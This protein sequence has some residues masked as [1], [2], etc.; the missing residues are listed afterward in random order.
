MTI[1]KIQLPDGRI[2]RFEVPQ[3]STEQ[4]VMSYVESNP[5]L[6]TAQEPEKEGFQEA[7]R[8]R[9]G[10]LAKGVGNVALGLPTGLGN[11]LVGGVQ[12][13]AD[14]IAPDSKFAGNLAEQ[15]KKR[16]QE[17]SNLPITER[18]GIAVGETLPFAA[19][20]TGMSLAKGGALV[21]GA[22]SGLA[23]KEE[24]GLGNRLKDTAIGAGIGAVATPIIGY[25][26]KGIGAGAGAVS[27]KIKN[28]FTKKT[29]DDKV[30]SIINKNI[31]KKDIQ[32]GIKQLE[33]GTDNLT[34]LDIESPAF[35]N[36]Y[37]TALT[38][39]PDSKEIANE[40]ARGRMAKGYERINKSLDK[41]SLSKSGRENIAKLNEERKVITAP[42]YTAAE[43][44]NVA[45]PKFNYKTIKTTE[46][47]TTTRFANQTKTSGVRRDMQTDLES[48]EQFMKGGK[49]TSVYDDEK[50]VIT[51][52]NKFLQSQKETGFFTSGTTKGD[53]I[54]KTQSKIIREGDKVIKED[55]QITNLKDLS[56]K[57]KKIAQQFERLKENQ[58]FDVAENGMKSLGFKTELNTVDD[59]ARLKI[60][61]DEKIA[62]MKNADLTR[63]ATI[64]RK[65]ID[66]LVGEL[67]PE[68]K[69]A[70]EIYSNYSKIIDAGEEGLNFTKM[71][72]EQI[73]LY[74]KSLN[75]KQLEA[76]RA[77]AK[78]TLLEEV[79]KNIVDFAQTSGK[80]K[81][82]ESI[83]DSAYEKSKIKALFR[84][85]ESGYNA[86]KKEMVD[87]IKYNTTL[88]RYGLT[89]A[90]VV[91]D[92]SAMANVAG[93]TLAFAAGGGKT[94]AL[95]EAGRFIEKLALKRYKGLNK[96][97]ANLLA[98]SMT[99]KENSLKAL[100]AA[101]NK[102]SDKEQKELSR[103]FIQDIS[104]ALTASIIGDRDFSPISNAEAAE[105]GFPSEKEY[106]DVLQKRK[107]TNPVLM[108]GIDPEKETKKYKQRFLK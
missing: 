9:L 19:M 48:T 78:E 38:K 54:T 12:T 15:V 73:D 29:P 14:I 40:F 68:R 36:M 30:S 50:G 82:A 4:D 90:Q 71:P 86:F 41:V 26:L 2:A 106:R 34:G 5:N 8:R 83:F 65:E 105:D 85:D 74:I 56:A 58:L 88:Q 27:S 59:L 98:K 103:K 63:R 53:T 18:A 67:N 16:N 1:A 69:V 107:K 33:E 84:G 25:G 23:M 76:Y 94:G 55:R 57:E 44:A 80:M 24:T 75:P 45:I 20:G 91:N 31:P 42:L 108:D 92:T 97:T 60:G 64:F 70:D 39:F 21:G 46:L 100:K 81:G 7:N 104:P 11:A 99:N 51:E 32:A 13:A 77:S 47:P 6:F 87:E 96:E 79:E 3:G 17:Q 52:G 62:T 66:G 102:I 101:Y 95:F 93:R 49:A 35:E 10:S 22:S 28:L 43:E 61:L 72:K 89:N 37:K